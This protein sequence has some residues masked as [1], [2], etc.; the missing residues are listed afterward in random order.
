MLTGHAVLI[1]LAIC[2]L[3]P[4]LDWVGML[5]IR[6]RVTRYPAFVVHALAGCLFLLGAALCGY[7][8][9]EWEWRSEYAILDTTAFLLCVVP[10]IIY[11]F[12]V[13]RRLLASSLWRRTTRAG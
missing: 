11:A 13:G 4:L 5:L 12:Q 2:W 1:A 7:L 8:G 3:P 10:L 6:F 9:S